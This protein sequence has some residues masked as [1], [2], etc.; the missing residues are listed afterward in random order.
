[1]YE[2]GLCTVLSDYITVNRVRVSPSAQNKMQ[3][4]LKIEEK[5]DIYAIYN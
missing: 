5:M 1:M 2:A 4:V 3:N